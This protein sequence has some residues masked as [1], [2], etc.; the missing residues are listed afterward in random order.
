MFWFIFHE[1]TD[2]I[3]WGDKG[4]VQLV[5]IFLFVLVFV[6]FVNLLLELSS[7]KVTDITKI[8]MILKYYKIFFVLVLSHVKRHSS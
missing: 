5:W 8:F 3:I 2:V 4:N 6:V 1:N 7:I